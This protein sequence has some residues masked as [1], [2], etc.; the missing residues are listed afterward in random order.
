MLNNQDTTGPTPSPTPT[1]IDLIL[2]DISD[3]KQQ[4]KSVATIS[5]I[6]PP[7]FIYVQLPSQPLPTTL[8]PGLKWLDVTKEYAGLFFRAEGAGSSKFD[9]KSIVVQQ[10]SNFNNFTV[11]TKGLS[12]VSYDGLTDVRTTQLINGKM[13]G[14]LCPGEALT[15]MTMLFGELDNKPRNT[16]FGL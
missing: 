2:K 16:G 9:D 3:I 15:S 8:W 6:L 10:A 5:T 4:L 7:G 14:E 12:K 13:S 1:P 11:N